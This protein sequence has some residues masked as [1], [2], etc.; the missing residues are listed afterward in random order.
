MTQWCM[1]FPYES[2]LK[3]KVIV[4]LYKM[5]VLYYI[6][7]LVPMFI[8]N[9]GYW[10]CLT[11]KSTSVSGFAVGTLCFLSLLRKDFQ[12]MRLET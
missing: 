11:S 5:S 1:M 8:F 9:H 10:Y 4:K 2:L 7:V 6:H 12:L 3:L